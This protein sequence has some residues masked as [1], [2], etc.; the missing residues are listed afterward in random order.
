[1]GM[2]RKIYIIL[3]AGGSGVRMGAAVPK[4]FLLLGGRPVLLRTAERLFEAWP[5][6]NLI[7]V[8]PKDHFETWK[9][10][11]RKYEFTRPQRL[12]EGGITRFH[13]VKNALA[14]V[15]DGATVAIHDGVRPLVS[16]KLL[17]GMRERMGEARALVPA[18]KMIDSLKYADGTLPEP[19]RSKI[20]AVQTPQ[21]FLS[22]EIKDAY[23]Q[24][25]DLVFTDDASVAARKEI[26]LS[27]IDGER[28]NLKITTPEDL[29][30]AELLLTSD[31]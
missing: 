20:I 21:M 28:F 11:C 31:L 17:R 1:M 8:L 19:D 26:P 25:Y 2:E 16:V 14:A 6:A 15:P 27:Y 13:S 4:Q 10:I 3:V 12:V 24:A 9:K 29:V 7:T 23:T 18:L 30:L 22:E 5:D